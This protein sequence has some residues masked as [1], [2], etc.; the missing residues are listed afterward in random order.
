VLATQPI[1]LKTLAWAGQGASAVKQASDQSLRVLEQGFDW[2]VGF[3][4][5]VWDWSS[6]QIVRMTQAPWETWPLWKQILLVIVAA[7]V[8]YGLYIAARQLW[9]AAMNVL[10]AVATFVGTLIV[11]LPTIL[12]A[13]AIALAGLWVINN[14]NSLSSLRSLVVFPGG[15][16]GH[17]NGTTPASPPARPDPAETIDGP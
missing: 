4:A 10:S 2:A 8:A 14:F 5:A 1:L 17:P 16:A 9:W 7:S 6:D 15:D 3:I 12:L 13:G 11:T